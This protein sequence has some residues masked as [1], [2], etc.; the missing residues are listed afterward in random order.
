M[1]N[2]WRGILIHIASAVPIGFFVY[3]GFLLA[4]WLG[5]MLAACGLCLW[6]VIG[7][8]CYLVFLP[9]FEADYARAK[10]LM[11]EDGDR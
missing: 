6:I 3:G 7:V 10:R 8:I 5:W 1:S 11:E 2:L 9:G 4:D